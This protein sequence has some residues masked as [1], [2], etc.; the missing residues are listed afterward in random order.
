MQ[1]GCPKCGNPK[2]EPI[3]GSFWKCGVCYPEYRNHN[4]NSALF[5]IKSIPTLEWLDKNI[6]KILTTVHIDEEYN[7]LNGVTFNQFISS[8][9]MLADWHNRGLL[10]SE[11]STLV[12]NIA[13]AYEELMAYYGITIFNKGSFL[14]S[15]NKNQYKFH[16]WN[17]EKAP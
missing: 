7:T 14:Y 5:R 9:Y 11:D 4:P 8:A 6:Y 13:D 2:A 15:T 10:W 1:W 12:L 3:V 17:L 16:F